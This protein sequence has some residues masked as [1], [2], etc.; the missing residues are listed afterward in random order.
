LI[1]E[2]TYSV[3]RKTIFLRYLENMLLSK[4]ML[5]VSDVKQFRKDFFPELIALMDAYEKD[6]YFDE[7]EELTAMLSHWSYQ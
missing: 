4:K 7:Y 6:L 5:L 2:T 1:S 3:N